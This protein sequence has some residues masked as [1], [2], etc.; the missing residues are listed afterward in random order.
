MEFESKFNPI[1]N[2]KKTCSII[3]PR[4]KAEEIIKIWKNRK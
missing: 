4:I 3:I 1:L 2:D